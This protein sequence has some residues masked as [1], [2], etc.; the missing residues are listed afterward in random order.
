MDAKYIRKQLTD[1]KI[2]VLRRY[3]RRLGGS[4][5]VPLYHKILMP[6]E[7]LNFDVYL[8]VKEDKKGEGNFLPY[9]QA[10]EVLKS[11]WIELLQGAGIE[12][13]YLHPQ[14]LEKVVAYLNNHL[15]TY[16][17]REEP[18]PEQMYLFREHLHF[19]LHLAFSSPK[20][21]PHIN[22][23][24]DMVG[25][26]IN[27]LEKDLAPWKLIS[28]ILYKDYNLYSHS[29]N[30]SLLSMAMVVFLRKS[31]GDGLILGLAGLFH[32]LGLTRIDKEIDYNKEGLSQEDWEI[33]K[34]HPAVGYKLLQSYAAMPE[35]AC[36]LVL[37]HHENADGSG[38]PRGLPLAQQHPWTRLMRLVDAYDSITS[39]RPSGPGHKPFAALKLLQEQRGPKGPVFE[40][41]TLKYFIRFLAFT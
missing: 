18:P 36:R 37:E 27:F 29:V 32:D 17:S 1:K 3:S 15:Q 41:E 11:E 7:R 19:S 9:V 4:P 14:D 16:S 8:F 20:M 28:E 21:G 26:V 39:H 2:K 5:F 10:G 40:A 23:A 13:L 34:D 33:L 6:G 31:K 30:V 12:R 24:K 35:E 25:N 22:L 38:Y